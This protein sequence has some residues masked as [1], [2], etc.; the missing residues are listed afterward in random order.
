MKRILN[1]AIANPGN[2]SGNFRPHPTLTSSNLTLKAYILI[3]VGL[4]FGQIC[5]GQT[6]QFKRVDIQKKKVK[7][8]KYSSY[9]LWDIANQKPTSEGVLDFITIENYDTLGNMISRTNTCIKDS[10]SYL[11]LC[12]EMNVKY[13]YQYDR[14]GNVV[15]EHTQRDFSSDSGEWRHLAEYK[16]DTTGKLLEKTSFTYFYDEPHQI[17]YYSYDRHGNILVDSITQR[18]VPM[19]VTTYYYSHKKLRKTIT[20][21]AKKVKFQLSDETKYYYNHKGL[22][23]RKTSTCNQS[24]DY[25]I[26]GSTTTLYRY[27][28]KNRLIKMQMDKRVIEYSYDNN[29]NIIKKSDYRELPVKR[30]SFKIPDYDILE[31]KY[32]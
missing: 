20:L 11:T 10:L 7:S 32:Y 21:W 22:L 16:Y 29:D 12:D 1:R 5:L 26:S 23:I 27:D 13:T 2:V 15:K 8:I 9:K 6:D 25:K 19:W 14:Y 4:L 28:R 30:Y 31:Y 3:I 24:T 17:N 18:G